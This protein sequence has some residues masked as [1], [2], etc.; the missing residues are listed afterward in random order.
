[1][2]PDKYES[3]SKLYLY[4]ISILSE[5]KNK[6]RIYILAPPLIS[7][8]TTHQTLESSCLDEIIFFSYLLTRGIIGGPWGPDMERLSWIQFITQD[9]YRLSRFYTTHIIV[10]Y[11]TAYGI[12]RLWNIYG[13]SGDVKW[14][15]GGIC[16]MFKVV[17]R[18]FERTGGSLHVAGYWWVLHMGTVNH[19]E[20]TGSSIIVDDLRRKCITWCLFFKQWNRKWTS[21]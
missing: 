3:D 4:K 15:Q 5:G 13:H 17:P 14:S 12:S 19:Q 21:Q 1:M 10:L 20:K 2:T 8:N 11:G 7:N 18:G 6:E 16:T 9:T